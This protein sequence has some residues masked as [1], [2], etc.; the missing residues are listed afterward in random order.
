MYF[1]F[2]NKKLS[3][4]FFNFTF[5]L[6]S[7]IILILFGIFLYLIYK[8]I[9]LFLVLFAVVMT[10]A[11]L[12]LNERHI[13]ATIQRRV[14][15]SITG[16]TFG[17]LQPL[18]D[19]L[20]L[21]T[22]ESSY[23]NKAN[24]FIFQLSPIFTFFLALFTWS[25][26]SLDIYSFILFDANYS[27]I[28]IVALLVINSYGIIFGSWLSNSKFAMLGAMR[29][30]A[31]SVSYGLS[32]TLVFLVPCFLAGSF[33]LREIVHFQQS[34]WFIWICLPVAILFW[35]TILTEIKKIPFDVSESEAELG[36][37]FLIEY[38][39]VNFAIF[40]VS[41]Y[42]YILIMLVIFVNLF[43]GGIYS[44]GIESWILYVCKFT[45]VVLIY[46][47]LR[48]ILPNLRFDQIMTLHWKYG[49]PV[50]VVF[51]IIIV[52]YLLFYVKLLLYKLYFFIF[53]SH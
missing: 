34:G 3:F 13:V 28:A 50:N 44:F 38:S 14:G 11:F 8:L 7:S 17:L 30:I 39:S 49:F 41:E 27:L 10:A 22:K 4:N 36:S 18:M 52:Q 2:K 20:K 6:N 19:G 29:S 15:P 23:P 26:I 35:I 33:N 25:F 48:S 31:L 37:G 51:F 53:I 5:L 16:G 21:I 32:L 45:F 12:S 40:V 43:F 1:G 9:G 47:N 42:I 46:F 24:K